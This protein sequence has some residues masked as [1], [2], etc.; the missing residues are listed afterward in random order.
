MAGAPPA[1]HAAATSQ[2]CA[3][4]ASSDAVR[5]GFGVVEVT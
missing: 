1:E 3:A 4:I 2:P 5:H